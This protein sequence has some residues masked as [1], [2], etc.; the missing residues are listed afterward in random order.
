MQRLVY[1]AIG[2]L[3]VL[4][5]LFVLIGVQ[6]TQEIPRFPG[7]E[8]KHAVLVLEELTYATLCWDISEANSRFRNPNHPLGHG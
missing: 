2:I 5:L 4:L 1:D 8:A 6:I 7:P 3:K